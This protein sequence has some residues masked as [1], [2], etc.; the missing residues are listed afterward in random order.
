MRHH[1]LVVLLMIA[2][3]L[4]GL[5]PPVVSGQEADFQAQVQNVV[6]AALEE[7]GVP[8]IGVIVVNSESTMARAV[9]GVR[10]VGT[11][12]S[13]TVDDQWHLGSN[14]K[15]MTATL[16]GM[17]VDEGR[18][19]WETTLEEVFPDLHEMNDDFKSVT[20]HQVLT[21][22]G[23][24]L[25]NLPWGL[26]PREG[27][28]A[29]A[30]RDAVATLLTMAPTYKPGVEAVYSNTGYVVAGAIIEKVTG[31]EWETV[32]RRDLFE[33][34]GMTGAGFGGLGTTGE[35]NQP[36]PHFTKDTP[37]EMNGPGADNPPVI[38][39]AG[40]VHCML[41]D[42]G[43]FLSEHLRAG[44]GDDPLLSSESFGVL[45]AKKFDDPYAA[46]WIVLER[47]WGGGVVMTHSGSNT[48]NRSVV[49]MAPQKDFAVAVMLNMGDQS[50][51]MIAD[52]VV[53]RVI[54][55]LVE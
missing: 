11:D 44:S 17:L 10:K 20:I 54:G 27:S 31:E 55:L 34:L 13:V 37:A 50:G 36:W 45:H 49:W 21:H 30:R 42:Y 7:H 39:P 41:E 5:P 19:D 43:R 16:V 51:A 48:M 53:T 2:P 29:K 24:F 25:S 28:M 38:A 8:A 18:L 6:D 12:V 33:P 23:G 3:L 14:T 32:I 47:S 40:T 9:A 22:R 1:L 52:D 4:M 15:A 35:I 26:M 46:G